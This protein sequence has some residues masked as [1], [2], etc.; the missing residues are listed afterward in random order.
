MPHTIKRT[1]SDQILMT[2][3]KGDQRL[4]QSPKNY[5]LTIKSFIK[6]ACRCKQVY[7]RQRKGYDRLRSQRRLM[8][9]TLPDP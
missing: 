4:C 7:R 3:K 9:G 1:K 6:A 8:Q 5:Y 2:N